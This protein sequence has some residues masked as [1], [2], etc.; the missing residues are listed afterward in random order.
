MAALLALLLVAIGSLVATSISLSSSLSRR[1]FE[2]QELRVALA[3][4]K[5]HADQTGDELR[6]ARSRLANSE[7]AQRRS[8]QREMQLENKILR[9][10][11]KV[12]DAEGAAE[13]MEQKVAHARMEH[14]AARIGE[15]SGPVITCN[16]ST[17][18]L[19]VELPEL[20]GIT[21][22]QWELRRLIG[23]ENESGGRGAKVEWSSEREGYFVQNLGHLGVLLRGLPDRFGE[24][25]FIHT[26]SDKESCARQCQRLRSTWS[27][28]KCSCGG[29]YHS[30]GGVDPLDG[31]KSVGWR[32]VRDEWVERRFI[33]E[34]GW[35]HSLARAA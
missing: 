27:D 30:S 22:G 3:H 17:S 4:G 11:R 16:R 18:E 33:L 5:R 14:T 23:D 8:Q 20:P 21:D 6:T 25:L 9:L 28:C 34:P 2:L 7:E 24:T 26:V 19:S 12:T 31:W 10:K 1:N 35:Y 13:T 29:V 32:A 15:F